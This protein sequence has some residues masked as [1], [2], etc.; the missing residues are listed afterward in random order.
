MAYPTINDLREA[1]ARVQKKDESELIPK[2]SD[3]EDLAPV[4]KAQPQV[5]E[6]KLIGEDRLKAGEISISEFIPLNGLNYDD[7]DG[8]KVG[9]TTQKTQ[10]QTLM[11]EM[12]GVAEEHIALAEKKF[13]STPQE[14]KTKENTLSVWRDAIN[15]IQVIQRK[16]E[17]PFT[18]SLAVRRDIPKLQDE[19]DNI[20]QGELDLKGKDL[21]GDA[22][23]RIANKIGSKKN[24]TEQQ[25]PETTPN[26]EDWSKDVESTIVTGKRR[27]Q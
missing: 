22:I 24:L 3:N 5:E 1:V 20:N 14:R 12:L 9:D 13:A 23:D 27:R 16:Y 17:N 6:N 25:K 10:Y 2:K 18:T 21:I 26:V 11:N 4:E 19:L 15:A 7:Y 8:W